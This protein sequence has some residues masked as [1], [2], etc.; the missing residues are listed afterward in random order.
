MG[1]STDERQTFSSVRGWHNGNSQ[2]IMVELNAERV[3]MSRADL[4]KNLGTGLYTESGHGGCMIWSASETF[5]RGRAT[6]QFLMPAPI[7]D[8]TITWNR[9]CDVHCYCRIKLHS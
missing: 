1:Y 5:E 8:F 3:F 7:L 4:E 2:V 9:S 6:I